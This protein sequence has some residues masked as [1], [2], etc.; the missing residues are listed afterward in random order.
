MKMIRIVILESVDYA[1]KMQIPPS[2]HP[3]VADCRHTR[4]AESSVA[5]IDQC[6]C[7]MLQ[8]HLGAFTVRLAPC[9]ALELLATLNAAMSKHASVASPEE[10]GFSGCA[11]GPRGQA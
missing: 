4:L 2:L 11:S 1:K 8:L 9:A 7:G 3:A 5:A 10:L 6:S